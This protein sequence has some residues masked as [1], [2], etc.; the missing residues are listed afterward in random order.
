MSSQSNASAQ[1]NDITATWG[2]L[3]R[4]KN[5]LRSL[6]LVGGVALYA[7]NMYI[8]TTILPNIVTDIGGLDYY[9]WNTTL[10]VVASIMGSALT[11]KT[12]VKLGPKG[13][14]IMALF[15]FALGSAW[16]ASAFAMW[17]LLVG[18]ALQGL[19]GG[20][21]FALGYTLIRIVFAKHLWTRA[22]ALVSGMWGVA[23]LLGPTI[24][25][26]FAQGGHWRWAFWTLLPIAGVLAWVVWQQIV[27]KTANNSNNPTQQLP[28]LSLSLLVASVVAISLA[29]LRNDWVWTSMTLGGGL[30][31]LL[32]MMVIDSQAK[33]KLLPTGS[34]R[35]SSGLCQV[36]LIMVLLIMGM[37]TEIFVPY[38]LQLLHGLSPLGAGYM[39]AFMSAGWTLSSLASAAKTGKAA[40]RL[41]QIGPILVAV[42]LVVLALSMPQT[43][44][45]VNTMVLMIIDG[46]ALSGI[47]FGIGLIWPHL[48][49]RV[50]VAAPS[51]EEALT[52]S[53]ITTVQLYGTALAAALAGVVANQ[54]GLVSVG[55][56]LGAQ[57]AA[58][59]LFAIF[60]LAPMVATVLVWRL[61]RH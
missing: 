58:W 46:I 2:D 27:G 41:M 40:H 60:A 57:S 36:Y 30:M 25:G 14:Y 33:H 1:S 15:V 18:R 8:V 34:Y 4:G 21:L 10:F 20:M 42:S 51:G 7:I 5:A 6:T 43:Q 44:T 54:A 55:G 17:F 38:F 12:M 26:F 3:F 35:F 9:S 31:M 39:T 29:S 16:C 47:G 61:L 28:W 49:N 52:A 37:T 24:G 59:Y 22:T 53:S 13:T 45:P 23:T 32:L 11:S 48:L 50:L 19:G 56:V